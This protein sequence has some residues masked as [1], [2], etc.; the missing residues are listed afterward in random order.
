MGAW[1]LA[2]KRSSAEATNTGSG[3][4]RARIESALIPGSKTP[5]PPAARIQSW[6]GCQ[7]RMSSFQV[8]MSRFTVLPA[9]LSAARFTAAL[10]W[11]W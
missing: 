8:A 7:R 11:A 10:C 4:M 9:S 5:K 1:R 3:R 6:P 2:G